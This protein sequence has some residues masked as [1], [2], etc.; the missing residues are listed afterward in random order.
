MSRPALKS[1][2]PGA[3]LGKLVDQF[4][5]AERLEKVVAEVGS[6]RAEMEGLRAAIEARG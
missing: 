3:A 2:P 5:A 6:A 4:R 1:V